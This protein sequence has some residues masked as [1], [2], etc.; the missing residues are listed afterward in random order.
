MTTLSLDNVVTVTIEEAQAGLP[1]FN[2]SALALITSDAPIPTN[3]GVF[4]IYLDAAGVASDFGSNSETFSIAT[5]IFAQSPNILTGGGYLVIIPRLA[6]APAS[7]ATILGTG[8][9][10]LTQLTATNYNIKLTVDGGSATACAI[11]SLD[12]TSLATAQASLNSTAVGTAGASF[13]LTGTLTAARIALLSNTTG[14]SSA[15]AI[16]ADAT[17][18][19]IAPLLTLSG[20]ATGTATGLES[21]KDCFLR[22]QPQVYFLG[23]VYNAIV[24]SADAESLAALCQAFDK[25]Q[26]IVSVTESDVPGFMTVIQSAGYSNTR[27]LYNSGTSGQGLLFMAAYASLAMS[28]DFEGSNTVQTMHLKSLIGV[29]PDNGITQTILAACQAA[30]VD[31]YPNFG[32]GKVFSSGSNEFYDQVYIALALKL[33]I[34]VAEFNLLATTNTKIAQ[35]EDGMNQLKSVVRA[36]MKQFVNNGAF[37]PGAWNAGTFG[38]PQ[39]FIRN[40][41]DVGFYV[42]SLPIAQQSQNVRNQRIAP[43]IQVAAKASGAIHSANIIVVIEA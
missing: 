19:D 26:F 2:T 37:A 3:F 24:A 27:C 38:D 32:Q 34:Q 15:L 1:G 35:T 21:Y 36:I 39:D 40:I 4:R 16:T 6:A 11:G 31:V 22:V 42:F 30:G 20:T 17:G 10:D 41:L 18:T 14:A 23:I 7:A 43:L 8:P 5:Q 9:V 29:V 12:L 33:S 25:I 13:V 28:T